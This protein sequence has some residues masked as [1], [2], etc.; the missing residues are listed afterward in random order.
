MKKSLIAGAI[1]IAVALLVFWTVKVEVAQSNARIFELITSRPIKTVRVEPTWGID[2][3]YQFVGW[4]SDTDPRFNLYEKR[5]AF[6]QINELESE[7][8]RVG[9]LV[10]VPLSSNRLVAKAKK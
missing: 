5:E 4:K 6:M 2:S 7:G 10:K 9:Q 1:F 3:C 8:L